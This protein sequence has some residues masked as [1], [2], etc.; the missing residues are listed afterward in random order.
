MSSR[1][2]AGRYELL[3]KI[4]DGGMA[5]VYKARC[6]LLNRYVAIKILKPQFTKD[7]KFIESFRRES[8]AAASLSHPNIVNVYDVGREGNINYIV[9]E[10]IEGK[11]LSDII[12]ERGSLSSQEA[13][14]IAKQIAFALSH[15]HKNQIIH[16]D[17][18]PHN[19][20][21]T[22]DG[23]AKITDFGIAKAVNAGTIVGQTGTVMGSV[24]YFSPEQARGGYVDEKS[25]IYSLGI[26][27]YEMLTGKVPFDADNPVAVAMKHI[28]DEIVPPS[29][30]VQGISPQLEEIVLKA[31]NKYQINRYKSAD[32]MLEALNQVD[33]NNFNIFDNDKKKD[34][35][36]TIIMNM[37]NS[38]E[39]PTNNMSVK[40]EEKIE[41]KKKGDKSLKGKK[42]T[43]L[44][45]I[46]IAAVILALIFSFPVSQLI[47]SAI[48]GGFHPKEVEVP[49]LIGYTVEEAEEILDKKDL[50][51]E[52]DKMV[53][54][55][56]YE[57]GMIVSQDPTE[58]MKVKTGKTIRVNISKGTKKG[59]IP[60]IIGKTLEDAV[61]I[62]ESYGYEKGEITE[63]NSEMPK[64]VIIKQ[65]PGA[66][67]EAKEGTAIDLVVSLGE[68]VETTT[69][70][71]LIGLDLNE[72]KT[73]LERKN[74]AFGKIDYAPSNTYAQNIVISQS[75]SSGSTVESGT[76]VNLTISTGPDK[77]AE[78]KAVK[79]PISYSAAQNEVF[80]LTVMVSDK[81]G[82]STPINYEQR[83]KS[84][85]SETFSVTGSGKGSV[86][87]YFDNALV[88][89]YSVDF[90]SGAIN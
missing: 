56:E 33:L 51:L 5:V 50:K 36:A 16:R 68:E 34:L 20:L 57:E 79:I 71:K 81:S 35:D 14:S 21:V 12:K 3:E 63:E 87:I 69:V 83:I 75:I 89:E 84:K 19:I 46:K 54:D 60:N 88:N 59:T 26:V 8:Q 70:P 41:E 66:G 31:T 25:D 7:I 72:A 76:P 45:K 39:P 67:K 47:L 53:S 10:L 40:P 85:G 24:H 6:K 32:E 11:V 27:L 4:G 17:V 28:N 64:G 48:Q 61:F 62:L 2:L 65:K 52:V 38:S 82:V 78:P 22:K 77:I 23:T 74:L 9:M 37:V 18:K 30:I 58:G 49:D 15:A 44:N 1:T 90:D 80:Y 13:V 86:K 29:Q 43:K 73:S 55:S 42:K